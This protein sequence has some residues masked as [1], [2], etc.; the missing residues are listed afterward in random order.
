VVPLRGQTLSDEVG[1]SAT[2]VYSIRAA[3][4][5]ENKAPKLGIA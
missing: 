1:S 3:D 4:S 2:V 5:A